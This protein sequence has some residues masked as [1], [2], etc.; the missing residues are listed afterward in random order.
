MIRFD[1]FG[2][3]FVMTPRAFSQPPDSELSPH[4]LESWEALGLGIMDMIGW[5]GLRCRLF[6]IRSYGDPS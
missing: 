3:E 1:F 2:S 6:F 5:L 4:H